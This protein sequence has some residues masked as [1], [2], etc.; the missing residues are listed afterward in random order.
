MSPVALRPRLLG[1]RPLLGVE[2]WPAFLVCPAG[3]SPCGQAP[4]ASLCLGFP[5]ISSWHS[6]PF[7]GPL[8][9]D[10]RA[11]ALGRWVPQ[12]AQ[13]LPQLFLPPERRTSSSM[14][15][16]CFMWK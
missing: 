4:P 2:A 5:G 1:G 11:L 8:P 14:D 6:S 9:T 3:E 12:G 10:G 15:Q 7:L 13:A 16:F